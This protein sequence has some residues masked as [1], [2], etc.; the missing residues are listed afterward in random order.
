MYFFHTSSS[1]FILGF[2]IPFT[3]ASLS[4]IIK[5]IIPNLLH[6]CLHRAHHLDLNPISTKHDIPI[7]DIRFSS[8]TTLNIHFTFAFAFL[9]SKVLHHVSPLISSF[10]TFPTSQSHLPIL[11]CLTSKSSHSCWY[12]GSAPHPYI[13]LFTTIVFHPSLP[14]TYLLPDLVAAYLTIPSTPFASTILF[15]LTLKTAIQTG[16]YCDT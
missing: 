7:S 16:L 2:T 13:S 15:H 8:N 9:S 11:F 4:Q 3:L 14:T 5:S 12:H 1:T 10:Q 6:I